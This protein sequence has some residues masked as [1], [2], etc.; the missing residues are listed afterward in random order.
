MINIVNKELEFNDELK[1]KI[2]YNRI[3]LD[4]IVMKETLLSWSHFKLKKSTI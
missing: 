2:E 4:Y 1:K 3:I